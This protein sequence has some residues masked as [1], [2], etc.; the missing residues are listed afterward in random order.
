[1]LGRRTREPAWS[2]QQINDAEL[3]LFY[4]LYFGV[5][6]FWVGCVPFDISFL[7]FLA[8]QLKKLQVSQKTGAPL[9]LGGEWLAGSGQCKGCQ[10]AGR[11]AC[12]YKPAK[13]CDR[14]I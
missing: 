14:K 9:T 2:D 1:M 10:E 12:A 13:E 5:G 11:A 6:Y 7:L 8:A 3:S 4:E